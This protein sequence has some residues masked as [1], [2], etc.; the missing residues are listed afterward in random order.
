MTFGLIQQLSF[1]VPGH[2]TTVSWRWLERGSVEKLREL[3][4]VVNLFDVVVPIEATIWMLPLLVSRF[5]L[6]FFMRGFTY[7]GLAELLFKKFF[8]VPKSNGI[9]NWTYQ[10]D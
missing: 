2:V 1:D 3:P 4:T 9:K 6:I 5:F 8:F 10:F 7:L